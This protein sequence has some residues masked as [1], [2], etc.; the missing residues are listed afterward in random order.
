[1][2]I[3]FKRLQNWLLMGLMGL[4]GF[5]GCRSAKEATEATAPDDGTAKER[6]RNE[7]MLMYG[8]I[9]RDFSDKDAVKSEDLRDKIDTTMRGR[10]EIPVMYGV[11]TVNYV[12]KGRVVDAKGAPVKGAQVVLLNNNVDIEPGS[13][14]Q[15][16]Y[17][18][19]YVRRSS[20]TT[21]DDGTFRCATTDMPERDMRVLVRDIDGA[22]NGT[23]KESMVEV[24]YK[25]AKVEG[26]RRGMLIGTAEKEVT[27]TVDVKK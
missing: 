23:I 25:D 27:V 10:K 22:K 3:R 9:P 17:V 18:R 4:L 15:T 16:D 2:K 19:N 5:T 14:P 11:P 7:V 8:A 26:E 12:L 24:S 21:A 6:P 13:M 1:M 20:D